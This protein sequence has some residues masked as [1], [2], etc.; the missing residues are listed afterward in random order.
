MK[1]NKTLSYLFITAAVMLAALLLTAPAFAEGESPPAEPVPQESAE[2]TEAPPQEETPPEDALSPP[3]PAEQAPQEDPAAE[4]TGTDE[5]AAVVEALAQADLSLAGADGETVSLASTQGEQATIAP[6]PYFKVGTQYYRWLPLTGNCAPWIAQGD[7]CNLSATPIQAAIDYIQMNGTI[8]TDRKIYVETGVYTE[9]VEIDGSLAN[10][11]TL[12]GLI[13]DYD[14]DTQTAPYVIGTLTIKNLSGGFTLQGFTVNGMIDFLDMAGNITLKDIYATGSNMGIRINNAASA[15]TF[16]EVYA[17][18]NAGGGALINNSASGKPY[19]VT[20]KN[21]TFNENDNGFNNVY[22]LDIK[23]LGK[24]TIE[25]VSASRNRG[26]GIYLDTDFSALTVKNAVLMSNDA[27]PDSAIYGYGLY[28]VSNAKANIILDMVTANDSKENTNTI[29]LVTAGSVT[30]NNTVTHGNTG[31]G[32][33]INNTTGSGPVRVTNSKFIING[34]GGLQINSRGPVYLSSIDA[35]Q[36]GDGGTFISTQ[37]TVTITSDKKLGYLGANDFS[38]NGTWGLYVSTSKAIAITNIIADNNSHVNIYLDNRSGTAGVTIKKTL[39]STQYDT[40]YNSA[41]GST[42]AHG[43][44]IRSKGAVQVEYL[45][46]DDNANSGIAIMNDGSAQ[47]PGI[48]VLYTEAHRNGEYGLDLASKGSVTFTNTSANHN[49]Q[50]QSRDGARIYTLSGTSGGVTI[51]GINGYTCTFNENSRRGLYL[52]V[53]GNVSFKNVEANLNTLSTYIANLSASSPRTV[54]LVNMSASG[55]TSSS[56]LEIYSTGTITLES[57]SAI[58]N[59]NYGAVLEN[60]SGTGSISVK[61]S[62]FNDNESFSG[63]QAF[64]SRN[65]AL[66]GIQ[67]LRNA[68]HGVYLDNCRFTGTGCSGSG[69][70]TISS[71]KNTY[72]E[73]S[74]HADSGVYI[75]SR[76]HVSLSNII[77]THNGV[78]GVN[79]NNSLDPLASGNVSISSAANMRNTISHNGNYGL[80]IESRGNIAVSN[81]DALANQYMGAYLYNPFSPQIKT[82]RVKDSTFVRNE[83]TGLEIESTGLVTLQG[84]DG[85]HNSRYQ[86]TVTLGGPGVSDV[87]SSEYEHDTHSFTVSSIST[88]YAITLN[89]LFFSPYLELRGPDGA[90]IDSGSGGGGTPAGMSGTL[91]TLGDYTIHVMSADGLGSGQYNLDL[92]GSGY[93][94]DAYRGVYITNASGSG[95]VK[96]LYSSKMGYGLRAWNN[97]HDGLRIM[98]NGAVSVDRAEV[99]Y[100]GY[101]GIDIR[102]THATENPVTLS[103]STIEGM[104]EYGVNIDSRGNIT[105]NK[106]SSL[107]NRR[108]GATLQNGTAAVNR[109]VKVSNSVFLH[110]MQTDNLG[111]FSKG[112]ITLTNIEASN[113][114]GTGTNGATISNAVSG[115]GNVTVSGKLNVFDNNA[116]NGLAINSYGDISLTNVMASNNG[117]GGI[118]AYNGHVGLNKKITLTASGGKTMNTLHNNGDYNLTLSSRGMVSVNKTESIGSDFGAYIYNAAAADFRKIS[119][120]NS[121]FNASN[122]RGLQITANGAVQLT[123]VWASDNGDLGIDVNNTPAVGEDVIVTSTT[124]RDNGDDGLFIRSAGMVKIDRSTA[125]GNNGHGFYVDNTSGTADEAVQ[126]LNTTS[127]LNGSSGI[128][129]YSDGALTLSNVNTISNLGHGIYFNGQNSGASV[130]LSNVYSA[131]NQQYGIDMTG[132]RNVT[133]SGTTAATNG[134]SVTNGDGLRLSSNGSGVVTLSKSTFIG[135]YGNGVELIN[136]AT[137]TQSNTIIFAND[138]DGSGDP[139][140]FQ[141]K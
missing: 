79:I 41:S 114:Q 30:V 123:N 1:T 104:Y 124:V 86:N 38:S 18:N 88:P 84:V 2:P 135:N 87:L 118:S 128:T 52:D 36:N 126:V 83:G 137:F 140:L 139:D 129:L 105:L 74:Y 80:L 64:S 92:G 75:I 69:S 4:D 9:T 91:N 77:A 95:G 122:H 25:N 130:T 65:I 57:F 121:V 90:L 103:N 61:N 115:G 24:V 35:S 48:K 16:D 8:P 78:R 111:I 70:V 26:A 37:N 99:M 110:A 23:T 12:N 138:V 11:G 5:T 46:A 56:G 97:T 3:E 32:L 94:L 76:G 51:T 106:V 47:S 15:V 13:G 66:N 108:T 125:S 62:V 29:Y 112:H 31:S 44:E 14:P 93:I 58:G 39:P 42:S 7:I 132:V 100:N 19:N 55:V 120:S 133:I 116:V 43:L 96:I 50:S 107:S 127:A 89:S 67:A 34:R 117:Y 10:L 141:W 45:I 119:V 6:D 28:A 134:S 68:V 81:V 85:S 20:I 82:V 136:V 40:F 98:S 60:H 101:Y 73:F 72:N 27:N 21:S 53:L 131:M 17:N 113:S 54:K 109:W 63:L 102:N 33:T 22:G 49:G 71:G 59:K